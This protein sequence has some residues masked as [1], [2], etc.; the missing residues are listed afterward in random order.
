[1]HSFAPFWNRSL[2]SIF[3]LKIAEIF[4]DF[5]RIFADFARILLNFLLNLV[6][7]SPNFF[8]IFPKCSH[9]LKFSENAAKLQIS[10]KN[11]GRKCQISFNFSAGFCFNLL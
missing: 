10:V 8:G 9:F 11:D 3:S 1:M 7:F 6:K 5:F 4:A 2:I